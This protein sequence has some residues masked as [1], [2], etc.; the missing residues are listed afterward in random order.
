MIASKKRA[1]VIGWPVAQSLS[2]AIH[3][4]W[5]REYGIEGEYTKAEVE[6]GGLPAFVA[7][8]RGEGFEGANVTIPHKIEAYD[9]CKRLDSAAKAIGAVNTLWFEG[10]ALCGSNTD[11]AGFLTNLDEQARGWDGGHSRAAVIG[12][13]GAALAIVWA[14]QNRG[15]SRIN[16]VNRSHGKAMDLANK[17]SSVVPFYFDQMSE[18]LIGAT[19]IANTSSLGMDGFP[20]LE[21]NLDSVQADAT[22]CDIVFKPLETALLRQA[23][24]RGLRAVDGLGMLMYQAVPGFE[25]WFGIE[26]SVTPALREAVLAAI[27]SNQPGAPQ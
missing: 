15:F 23:R 27:A 10:E 21:I 3:G 1:C 7:A 9:L 25:K 19:F 4:F 20:P 5:L 11:A 6:P 17:F 14:L 13:G 24:E 22:V 12:A 26:P 8:M 18:A 16:I 2:P